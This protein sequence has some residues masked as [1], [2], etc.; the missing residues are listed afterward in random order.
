MVESD[1]TKKGVEEKK[2]PL[3]KCKAYEMEAFHTPFFMEH[4]TT[5]NH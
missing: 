4:L 5:S 1:F 3:L 2:L